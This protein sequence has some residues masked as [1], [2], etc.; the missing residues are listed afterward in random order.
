MIQTLPAKHIFQ[1]LW[2]TISKEIA[3]EVEC[4]ALRHNTWTSHSLT[5][6][7]NPPKIMNC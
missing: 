7:N 5:H 2:K 3:E 4:E 1:Q 6:N